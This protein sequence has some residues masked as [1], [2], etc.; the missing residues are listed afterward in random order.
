MIQRRVK[1]KKGVTVENG[2]V[3]AGRSLGNGREAHD[4]SAG[5]EQVGC[6]G[7]CLLCQ[8]LGQQECTAVKCLRPGTNPATSPWALRPHLWLREL[9]NFS[10]PQF[11]HLCYG[12]A[13][14]N[15]RLRE[16]GTHK[17]PAAGSEAQSAFSGSGYG[18]CNGQECHWN[19]PGTSARSSLVSS[20]PSLRQKSRTCCS[21]CPLPRE[22]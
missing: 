11:L 21:R 12:P 17:G 10:K 14:G 9:F 7:L 1:W 2:P 5:S 3:L 16:H 19:F 22:T 15:W 6:T 8:G 4:G 18:Y 20:S 13:N